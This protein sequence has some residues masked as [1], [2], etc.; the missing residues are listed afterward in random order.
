MRDATPEQ[1]G[2]DVDGIIGISRSLRFRSLLAGETVSREAG[3]L[4]FHASY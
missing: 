1:S 4:G 2:S 3:G